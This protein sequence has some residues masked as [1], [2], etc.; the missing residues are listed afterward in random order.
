MKKYK[1]KYQDA[2]FIK[3]ITLESS[4]I[5]NE[6]LPKNI[7]SIEEYKKTFDLNYFNK[8]R[9]NDKKLNLLFYDSFWLIQFFRMEV[10]AAYLF[11]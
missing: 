6:K 2:S 7:I 10:C 4:N 8:K 1:I 11:F 5:T 9:I 3:E